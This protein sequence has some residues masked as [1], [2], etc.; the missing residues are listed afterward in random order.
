VKILL[1]R[2]GF[3][4]KVFEE[5][6]EPER[7]KIVYAN[8]YHRAQKILVG[9]VQGLVSHILVPEKEGNAGYG[10]NTRA[11]SPWGA[12]LA[13]EARRLSIPV[14]L[15]VDSLNSEDIQHYVEAMFRQQSQEPPKIVHLY[16]G[17]NQRTHSSIYTSL[18]IQM[19][20]AKGASQ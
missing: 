4:S 13:L 17:G 10:H 9:G 8:T 15:T 14:I 3:L 5:F 18:R 7:I 1:V 16:Q 11:V 6:A 19:P 2:G 12:L 20:Q